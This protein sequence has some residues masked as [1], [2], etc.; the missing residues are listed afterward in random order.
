MPRSFK[1]DAAGPGLVTPGII[2]GIFGYAL[3]NYVGFA[4]AYVTRS[5]L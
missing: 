1:T 3:G 2:L 5:F 4:C